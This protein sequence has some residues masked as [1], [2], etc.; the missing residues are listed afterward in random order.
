T[1]RGHTPNTSFPLR[2]LDPRAMNTV[3]VRTIWEDGRENS[4]DPQ[5]RDSV[6]FSVAALAPAELMLSQLEPVRSTAGWRGME[7]EDSMAGNPVVIGGK[8]Y[9]HGTPAVLNS[10]IEYDL[11]GLY[12]TF[13]AQ[14]GMDDSAPGNRAAVFSVTGDGKELWHS[15]PLKKS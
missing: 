5:G 1:L 6:K 4:P 15:E 12:D 7:L 8:Q 9:G 3:Q 13:S 11:E 10:E 2:G 14:V